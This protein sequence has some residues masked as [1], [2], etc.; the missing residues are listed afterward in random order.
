MRA[1]AQLLFALALLAG[2]A[3]AQL[4][5]GTIS[6]TVTDPTSASLANAVGGN[7]T[8]QVGLRLDF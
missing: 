4:D 2:T 5:R 7:R 6:G 3:Y 8:G 1:F